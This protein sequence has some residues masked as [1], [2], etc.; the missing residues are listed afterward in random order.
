MATDKRIKLRTEEKQGQQKKL[1][2]NLS[3][4]FNTYKKKREYTFPWW[5]YCVYIERLL[6]LV[7]LNIIVILIT[8]LFKKCF[9]YF[10]ILLR[11]LSYFDVFVLFYKDNFFF[12]MYSRYQHYFFCKL[13]KK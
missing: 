10:F 5:Y 11:S 1:R 8:L 13:F 4:P 12:F 2:I 3:Y 9:Y 6:Y 7:E